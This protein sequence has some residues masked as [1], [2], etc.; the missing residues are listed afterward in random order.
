MIKHEYFMKMAL[1]LARK[2]YGTANPNPMVGAVI[3]KNN[4]IVATAYHK[5][6]GALHAEAI[7]LKRA[8]ARAKGATLYVNLEPCAHFGRTPPCAQAIIK[9]GIKKAYFSM[10]DPNPLNNGKGARELKR[11]GVEAHHGILAQEAEKL[12]EVFVKYIAKNMP[13]V[14]LKVAESLDGK[15]AAYTGDS[16]WITSETSRRCG[17]NLRSS[18]DA[19]LVGINTV[20][21][22]DPLLTSRRQR[23]PIKVILGAGFR[24]PE[25]ARIFSKKSPRLSIV[26]ISKKLL[27]DKKVLQK[28]ERLSKKGVLVIACPEKI[29]R[30]DLRYLL[31]ELAELEIA[32]LLVEGGGE[33]IA[34]FI[35]EELADRVLF[36]IAP[37][38]MG[39]RNAVTSVEGR[40]VAKVKNAFNLK[41]VELGR[42]GEDILIKGDL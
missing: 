26:A 14:T 37:K 32:H 13:F 33:T 5:R 38:I 11:H 29:K 27:I 42:I 10:F 3:V 23:S 31:R 20:L 7:A 12:N 2:G 41:N 17:H 19:V 40:G 9:S 1:E 22:D 18:V 25:R 36:F 39:G 15:I 35:E 30:I 34:S 24:V 16:K 6:P 28:I 21:R 8:G 4:K